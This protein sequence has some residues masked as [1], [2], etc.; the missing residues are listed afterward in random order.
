MERGRWT[1]RRDRGAHIQKMKEKK[2]KPPSP[3][4][5]GER[6]RQTDTDKEKE[7]EVS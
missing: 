6:G 1:D 5:G 4:R 2:G 7:T 3:K